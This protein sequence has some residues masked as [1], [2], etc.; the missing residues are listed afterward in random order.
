M[1]K[2]HFA[3][4]PDK[5][6]IKKGLEDGYAAA[7]TP[8]GNIAVCEKKKVVLYEGSKGEEVILTSLATFGYIFV[9]EHQRHDFSVLLAFQV[10]FKN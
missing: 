7:F 4:K 2:I 9:K 10:H 5:V 8:D 1:S 6:W 3:H